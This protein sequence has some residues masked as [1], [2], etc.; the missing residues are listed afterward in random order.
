MTVVGGQSFRWQALSLDEQRIMTSALE[1]EQLS[2]ALLRW[3]PLRDA[4]FNG[5]ANN[6]GRKYAELLIPTA[7]NLVSVGLIAVL[8]PGTS[9][10][11][12]SRDDALRVVGDV[13]NWWWYSDLPGLSDPLESAPLPGS[14]HR[15]WPGEDGH[16][17]DVANEAVFELKGWAP[18][19]RME[20]SSLS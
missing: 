15:Q 5:G 18:P 8:P 9:K 1:R 20:P 13:N 19:P 2:E 12:M 14:N 6:R 3:R 4:M 17:L 10:V 11:E 16:Y 7:V